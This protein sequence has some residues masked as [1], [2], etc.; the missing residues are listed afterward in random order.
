[1]SLALG[2]TLGRDT[3]DQSDA[4]SG[5]ATRRRVDEGTGLHDWTSDVAPWQAWLDPP[6]GIARH[7]SSVDE[8][9]C[10]VIAARFGLEGRAPMTFEEIE[11]ELGV[12]RRRAAPMLRRAT[13]SAVS[14]SRSV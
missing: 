14:A 9:A 5:R 11:A 2:R 12:S 1:V 3:D 4:P 7:V 8:E 10:R 6:P 13:L